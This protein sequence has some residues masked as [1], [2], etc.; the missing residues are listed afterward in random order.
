MSETDQ[1]IDDQAIDDQAAA[2]W[3]DEAVRRQHALRM[4]FAL[5]WEADRVAVAEV[6][7]AFLRGRNGSMR[8]LALELAVREATSGIELSDH[9]VDRTNAIMAVARLN[10]RFLLAIDG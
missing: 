5:A 2:A 6:F 10:L 1:A 7:F 4:A 3:R 9:N 8:R